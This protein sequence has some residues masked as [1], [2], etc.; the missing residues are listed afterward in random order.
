MNN[1]YYSPYNVSHQTQ[2]IITPSSC[3]FN[4]VQYGIPNTQS[5]LFRPIVIPNNRINNVG[6]INPLLLQNNYFP[7][8]RNI[9][10]GVWQQQQQ[11]QQNNLTQIK[12]REQRRKRR[13]FRPNNQNQ[14]LRNKRRKKKIRI[15]KEQQQDKQSL[16]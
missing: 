1:Q 2:N 7:K 5:S 16:K 6:L 8:T 3:N 4:N 11:Q 15:V 10:N 14:Y 13:H 12:R 9:Q